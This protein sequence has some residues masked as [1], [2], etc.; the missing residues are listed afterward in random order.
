MHTILAQSFAILSALKNFSASLSA[1][2]D[3][4]AGHSFGS[5]AIAAIVVTSLALA[6][7]CG[8]WA[9][10]ERARRGNYRHRVQ[11]VLRRSQIARHFRDS[12]L[13]SL[14]ETVVVLRSRSQ[15]ALSY[16]GGSALLQQCL[17]GPDAAPLATAIDDLLRHAAGFSLSVRLSGLRQVFVRGLRISNGT[18]LFLRAQKRYR[19]EEPVSD[20]T[21]KIVHFPKAIALAAGAGPSP[22]ES[23][24]NVQPIGGSR[25]GEIVIGVDGR[26]KQ[27][28]RAFAAQW[29]FSGDELRGEPLWSEVAERCIARNGRDP[30]WDIVSIAVTAA[31]PERLNA[32][33][34]TIRKDGT[35]IWLSVA[36]LQ[37]GSTRMTFTDSILPSATPTYDTT[38]MAA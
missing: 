11:A 21:P 4:L 30:I 13:E 35:R 27:H 7:G 22:Q 24:S 8:A 6:A 2:F 33:G 14:P 9:I 1:Q 32:W 37:D 3:H 23:A 29:S 15:Q 5:F 18:A 28:N 17:A 20:E 31:E 26:L 12:I 38:A 36:R 34:A 19:A 10:L 16:G 25:V